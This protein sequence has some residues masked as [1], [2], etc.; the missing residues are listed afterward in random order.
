M[1]EIG[2]VMVQRP[3]L[4]LLDEP[5][6]GM[7]G[8]EVERLVVVIQRINQNAAVIVV[9][10]DMAFVRMLAATVTV[11]HRGAILVEGPADGVLRDARVREVYLGEAAA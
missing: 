2:V 7:T 11:F 3:T 10:H 9:D 5:A 8:D 6:A 1:V 4:V